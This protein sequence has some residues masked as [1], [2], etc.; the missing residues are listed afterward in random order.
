MPHLTDRLYTLQRLMAK[1]ID[2]IWTASHTKAFECSKDAILLCATLMYY[3][4]EKP[5]TIQ[6]DASNI[7]VGAVL[8]QDEKVIEYHSRALTS[9]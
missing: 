7:C 3:D 8:I 4:D 9:T 5:C 2:F 1:D 6:V